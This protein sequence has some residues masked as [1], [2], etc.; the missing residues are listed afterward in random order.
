MSS[1]EELN[2]D[3]QNICEDV[4]Q[5]IIDF[6]G[7]ETGFQYAQRT[8]LVYF[9][10]PDGPAQQQGLEAKIW[11]VELLDHQQFDD[12]LYQQRKRGD[13]PFTIQ[14][15]KDQSS[16]S[17][18]AKACKDVVG[19]AG[20]FPD[21]EAM[22]KE[23]LKN[24]I[25]EE[26]NVQDF[27]KETGCWQRIA[28]SNSFEYVTLGVI[29]FNAIWLWI[30]TDFNESESLLQA[31]VIFQVAEHF[32]CAFFSAEWLIRFMSFEY[33]KHCLKDAWFIFDTFMVSMMVMETWCITI[34]MVAVGGGGE[35]LVDT[36][37]LRLL[38]LM[39]LTRISRMVRLLRA[40][41]ELLFML[42]GMMA[43]TR[44]VFFTM[45]LL[46][47]VLYVFGIICR[48][49][50]DGTV[51]G[52]K[53][54]PTVM[55]AMYSLSIHAALLDGVGGVLTEVGQESMATG[56]VFSCTIGLAS[57]TV[58][59]MLVG[60]LCEVVS[61]VAATEKEEMAVSFVKTKVL[62]ILS[63]LSGSDQDDDNAFKE[64]A[65]D[66]LISKE[67]FSVL[68]KHPD[69]VKALK[70]VGVDVVTL[71][72]YA[73]LIFQSDARGQSFNRKLEFHEFMD[74]V[75]MLRGGNP[76]TVKDIADLRKFIHGQNTSR[77]NKLSE[78]EE[79]L[80]STLEKMDWMCQAMAES[81]GK[82]PPTF[83]GADSKYKSVWADDC[84]QEKEEDAE[85][86]ANR[87]NRLERQMSQSTTNL[88]TSG[89]IKKNVFSVGQDLIAGVRNSAPKNMTRAATRTESLD[90]SDSDTADAV[91]QQT[92][93][94]F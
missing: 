42:K 89:K 78:M 54:F 86:L 49:L 57:L 53:Y 27:Y 19:R 37:M 75:L 16:E 38:R 3:V 63:I 22:K 91:I 66:G 31:D 20:L 84:P 50:A 18:E 41:P 55:T 15:S 93:S 36:S 26:Y 87:M 24:S 23:V 29:S 10:E 39:R 51:M 43:A 81:L 69:A 13:S 33:K 90:V 88:S 17:L 14:F 56:F 48:Q 67:E 8:G 64:G 6:K 77:N 30:D 85:V 45:T 5:L 60:V 11:Y 83:G 62:H 44:S 70:D 21:K 2:Q 40:M 76:A 80:D 9:V 82:P 35:A 32:F 59:N 71:V 52:A 1:I 12:N 61:A 65:E 46:I 4:K 74:L 34:V 47:L 92:R 28:R 7:G 79:K 72:D 94:V 25:I 73:S 68:M 58:L